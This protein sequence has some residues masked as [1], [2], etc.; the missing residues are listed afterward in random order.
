MLGKAVLGHLTPA[1]QAVVRVRSERRLL[2]F[3]S[4]HRSVAIAGVLPSDVSHRGC[5]QEFLECW[6]FTPVSSESAMAAGEWLSLE[7][8]LP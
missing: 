8:G 4:K 6:F 3:R 2:L 7:V 5:G 1:E